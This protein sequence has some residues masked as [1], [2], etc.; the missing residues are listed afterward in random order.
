M[1]ETFTE[2]FNS[3][4]NNKIKSNHEKFFNSLFHQKKLSQNR[5]LSV[6]EMKKKLNQSTMLS[7]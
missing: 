5:R 3:P 1:V 2:A 7:N 6:V 4:E